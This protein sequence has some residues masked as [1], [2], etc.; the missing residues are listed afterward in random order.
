MRG[1]VA[2][3]LRF[4][5]WAFRRGFNRLDEVRVC[6]LAEFRAGRIKPNGEPEV[7]QLPVSTH[8]TLQYSRDSARS[9][10]QSLKKYW[11]N[12]KA[13]PVIYRGGF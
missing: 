9:L 7:V 12:H 1:S 8:G 10:Y 6:G 4:D 3:K 11:H 5:A 13:I 2:K